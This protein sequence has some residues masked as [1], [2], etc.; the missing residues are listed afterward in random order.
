[1]GR[2]LRLLL[3]W[4]LILKVRDRYVIR[5][6]LTIQN[7]SWAIATTVSSGLA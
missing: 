2:K 7:Q 3:V 5:H 4:I 1:M 6:F